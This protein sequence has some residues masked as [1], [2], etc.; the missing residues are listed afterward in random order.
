MFKR[1]KFTLKFR[2]TYQ[3]VDIGTWKE[4]THGFLISTLVDL[5]K[6]YDF[7]IIST[8]LKDCFSNSYITIKCNKEDKCKIFSEYCSILSGEIENISF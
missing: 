4:V 1:R 8:N 5:Q 3:F 7:D 2:K 6:K